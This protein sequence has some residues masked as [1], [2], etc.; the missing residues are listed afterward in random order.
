MFSSAIQS[1]H[2]TG[3]GGTALASATA[4]LLDK[5]FAVTGSDQ[6]VYEPMASFLPA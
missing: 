6:N 2:F 4:G 5:D 3:I 1:I